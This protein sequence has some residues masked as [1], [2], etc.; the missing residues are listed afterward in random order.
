MFFPKTIPFSHFAKP[1]K[2][3]KILNEWILTRYHKMI[4]LF[5][6]TYFFFR[7]SGAIYKYIY[8]VYGNSTVSIS[9]TCFH[10]ITIDFMH[11][12]IRCNRQNAKWFNVWCWIIILLP[13]ANI[14]F[15]LHRF[16]QRW[17]ETWWKERAKHTIFSVCEHNKWN[18]EKKNHHFP[19]HFK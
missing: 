15:F 17:H 7:L 10:A 12:L 4:L 9:A 11:T 1:N 16:R 5:I 18:E 8:L 3:N 13:S 19:L 14:I 2:T 6:Q